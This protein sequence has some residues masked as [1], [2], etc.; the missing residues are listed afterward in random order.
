MKRNS[1]MFAV[2]DSSS[3]LAFVEAEDKQGVR[4]RYERVT[5]TPIP[6]QYKIREARWRP[7]SHVPRYIYAGDEYVPGP[8]YLFYPCQYFDRAEFEPSEE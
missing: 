4:V 2:S 3:N 8:N 6:P 1:R 5:G 7:R